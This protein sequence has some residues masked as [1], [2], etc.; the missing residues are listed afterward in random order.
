M[1]QT[2][3]LKD[4]FRYFLGATR[5]CYKAKMLNIGAWKLSLPENVSVLLSQ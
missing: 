4:S 5:E 3:C 1:A 2:F